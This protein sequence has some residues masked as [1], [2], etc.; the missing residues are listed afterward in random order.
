MGFPQARLLLPHSCFCLAIAASRLASECRLLMPEV[1]LGLGPCSC[2]CVCV[3]VRARARA[4]ILH[5]CARAHMHT[6][7]GA[8]S[9]LLIT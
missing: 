2:V 8:H 7:I 9:V 3:C 4:R 5:Q 6:P 1:R